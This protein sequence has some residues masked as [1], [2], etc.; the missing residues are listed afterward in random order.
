MRVI[1]VHGRGGRRTR[2]EVTQVSGVV[3]GTVVDGCTFVYMQ[4]GQYFQVVE[5]FA[6]VT[7]AMGSLWEDPVKVIKDE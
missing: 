2:I 3:E 5:S 4:S 6:E 1:E 7:R